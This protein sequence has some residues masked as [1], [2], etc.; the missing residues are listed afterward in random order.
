VVDSHD[1]PTVSSLPQ[2]S[3]TPAIPAYP[4]EQTSET[5]TFPPRFARGIG[6]SWR[7][8]RLAAS[9]LHHLHARIE[10]RDATRFR[11]TCTKT[12][13]PPGFLRPASSTQASQAH[14]TPHEPRSARLRRAKGGVTDRC[15]MKVTTASHLVLDFQQNLCKE[16]NLLC[17]AVSRI[18]V[19]E[20]CISI[21]L[22]SI[23]IPSDRSEG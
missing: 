4:T 8:R 12:R 22:I 7:A 23:T 11:E 1:Q 15:A 13:G 21:S 14:S 3:P 9:P 16:G 2:V 18:D 20:A 17:A 6:T 19:D 10:S 5:G